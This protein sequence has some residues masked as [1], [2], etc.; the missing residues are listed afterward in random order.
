M[1]QHNLTVIGIWDQRTEL[2]IRREYRK[3]HTSSH[4]LILVPGLTFPEGRNPV[5][6][7]AQVV[8][9]PNIYLGAKNNNQEFSEYNNYFSLKT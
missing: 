5:T 2:Q 7:T 9:L 3:N 6:L 1:R 4:G 8:S